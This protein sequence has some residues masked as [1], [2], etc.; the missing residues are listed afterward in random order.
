MA[1]PRIRTRLGAGAAAVVVAVLTPIGCN[2]DDEPA[3]TGGYCTIVRDNIVAINSPSI[4][5]AA[6]VAATIDLYRSIAAEAPLAVAE[7]WQTM[8]V[9]LET[10]ATVVADDPES[11]IAANDA[12][13]AGQP[14]YSRIQQFT[15]A[16]CTQ[17]IGIPPARTTPAVPPTVT[18]TDTGTTG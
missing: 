12:A 10:V 3:T 6:D 14:A 8:L 4:A 7:E 11:V 18:L 5:T 13:L 9:N 1:T 15:K 2:G 17:D 16:T